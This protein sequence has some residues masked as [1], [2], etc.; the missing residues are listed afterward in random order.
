MNDFLSGLHDFFDPVTFPVIAAVHDENG[1]WRPI[2]ANG[3]AERLTSG[4][5]NE[6]VGAMSQALSSGASE[7]SGELW[8]LDIDA[9][10][11]P[12][13]D[14][15]VM[16]L[17]RDITEELRRQQKRIDDSK[18][19]LQS[20]LDAANA[21]SRA[22]TEFLSNMSHDIRTPLN[23]IIGMTTIAEAHLDERERIEDCLEKIGL[24][25]RHLL[26][27]IN[28]ILDMSR[29]ESGKLSVSAEPFALADLIHSIMAIF[30]PQA[31]KKGLSVK[32]DFTGIRHENV[33]GD[34]VRISQILVNILS[35]AVKFTKEGGTVSFT[36]RETGKNTSDDINYCYYEFIV[37]DTGIGMSPEFLKKLFMPFERDSSV[38]HIEGTGL[39]MAITNNLVKMMNGEISVESTEGV[40]TKFTV[41]LP[42]EQLDTDSSKLC[43][44][45]GL[46]VLA[47]DADEHARQNLRE[48]LTDLDM[49]CDIVGSAFEACSLAEAH[50]AEG[51]DYFAVILS[52]HLPHVN[53]IDLCRELRG[54]V[55][56]NIPII[57]ISSSEWTLSVDEMRKYGISGFVPKPLFRSRL[58]ETL[59]AYT[60]EGKAESS[61]DS[62]DGSDFSGFKLL[63]V[64]DNEINREIGVELLEMLGASVDCAEDGKEA[65][66]K[67]A[68]SA[69][70]TYDF[71]FMDIQMPVMN[72]LDAAK[73]IRA[74]PRKDASRIPIVAMSAN[75]F[76]EDI[77]ACKRAGMDDHV[78][79]PVSLRSLIDVMNKYLRS[80]FDGHREGSE[81][82]I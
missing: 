46:S 26:S 16:I 55:G 58:G 41:L 8:G 48:I 3:S 50:H 60:P 29:I 43:A 56:A 78:P 33:R 68:S 28:D 17:P 63:L 52:L 79:K 35:N 10:I 51:N 4:R 42:L 36:I 18:A 30:K 1:I 70:G 13:T 9:R 73:A 25:S 38:N 61:A 59:Y 7:W 23:A 82:D 22:K 62:D 11:S 27:I 15:T 76:V 34:D 40:G 64:E 66:D 69:P 12:Y 53:G 6:L 2:F 67:F 77:R 49:E 39:G 45:R 44:L 57:I 37:S 20:A 14:G 72:G 21:A 31:D 80:D 81:D 32:L 47:A 24:S 74:L 65:V 75:A 19:A 5:G 71:I 54:T